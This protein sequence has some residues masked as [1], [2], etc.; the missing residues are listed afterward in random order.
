[1]VTWSAQP[2]AVPEFTRNLDLCFSTF[3]PEKKQ[4]DGAWGMCGFPPFCQIARSRSFDS[5]FSLSGC[6]CSCFPGSLRRGGR[7]TSGHPH[8]A[9]DTR[10]TKRMGHGAFQAGQKLTM[11]VRELKLCAA[12]ILACSPGTR[13][14][15][16]PPCVPLRWPRPPATGH[17]AYRRLQRCLRQTTCSWW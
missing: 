5:L 11:R 16:L 3:L 1:M 10:M 17:G 2:K 14:R 8:R 4:K 9:A 15:R 13:S 12:K 7:G 6:L